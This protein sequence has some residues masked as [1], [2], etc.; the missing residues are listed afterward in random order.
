MIRYAMMLLI[1]LL[2]SP[3]QLLAEIYRY[4]DDRGTTHFVDDVSQVP[5]KYRKATR[6]A[7]DQPLNI[8]ATP[9]ARPRTAK[10]AKAEPVPEEQSNVNVEIYV[11]S[12]CGYCKKAIRYLNEK[13][14]PYTAYD[15]EQDSSANSRYTALGGN[16]VPLISI[17][18]KVIRGFSPEAISRYTGR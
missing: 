9:P 18:D 17:G 15:I 2:C 10:Q 5:K 8:V 12:W 3:L 13:G 1:L 14:I 6:T 4:T 16:G 11:T 7:D